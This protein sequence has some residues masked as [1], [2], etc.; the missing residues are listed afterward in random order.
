M[1]SQHKIFLYNNWK[2]SKLLLRYTIMSGEFKPK[3]LQNGAV[4]QLREQLDV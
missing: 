4:C 1:Q 3:S 2:T